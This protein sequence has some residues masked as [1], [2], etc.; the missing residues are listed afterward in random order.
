MIQF[1]IYDLYPTETLFY[2]FESQTVIYLKNSRLYSGAIICNSI[3]LETKTKML[4]INPFVNKYVAW[5]KKTKQTVLSPLSH[6]NFSILII[7]SYLR[8]LTAVYEETS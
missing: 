7:K 4:T 2:Q 5:I 8:V 1:P 6:Y 3:P